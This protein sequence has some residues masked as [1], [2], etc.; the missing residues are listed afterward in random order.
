MEI[1]CHTQIYSALQQRK[2]VIKEELIPIPRNKISKSFL[3]LSSNLNE[4]SQE[5]MP[6]T[7]NVTLASFREKST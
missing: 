6:N 4:I 5:R 7:C 3:E 2:G 1:K